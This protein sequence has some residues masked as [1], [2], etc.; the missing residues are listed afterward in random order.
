MER[1]ILIAKIKPEKTKEFLQVIAALQRDMEKARSGG[2]LLV[3]QDEN[4]RTAYRVTCEWQTAEDR[5][6]Y[7]REDGRILLGALKTL[8]R[9]PE[10]DC[11]CLT[12]EEV[13]Q[14][15]PLEKV[16]YEN[17]VRLKGG[18]R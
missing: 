1:T 9:E 13:G 11:S 6:T 2:V 17:W 5:K 8:C 14:R 10:V 7:F 3:D 4:D 15:S 18:L 16:S 12:G